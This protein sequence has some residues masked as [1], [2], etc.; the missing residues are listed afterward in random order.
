MQIIIIWDDNCF[1]PRIQMLLN[2]KICSKHVSEDKERRVQLQKIDTW[3]Q[4]VD[5]NI[6]K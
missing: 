4:K 3:N 1:F 6:F 2:K 5:A